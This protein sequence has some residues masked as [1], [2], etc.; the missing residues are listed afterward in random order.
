VNG[1]R[2]PPVPPKRERQRPL[3]WHQPKS[4]E[5]DAE[6]LARVQ[7][8]LAS[9]TYR[10]ADE[11][12]ALL[13]QPAMRGVRLHLDYAKAE[14]VLA[15]HSI[16]HAIIVFGGTRISEPA[17][18]ERRLAASRAALHA[19]PR[20][21]DAQRDVRIAERIVANSRYYDVARDLGRIA[22]ASR[23][24]A[25]GHRVVVMTGAGPG[26]MEAANR[27]A[28]D[29]GA[30]TAGLNVR[31]AN[32]QFPN[33]Y[34][35]PEL[36]FRF[37]YFAIRKLHFIQRAKAIVV[38]PG[39]YGTFDELFEALALVQT[40]TIAPIP[41]VLVGEDYWRRAIDFAF[42][43]DEGVVD[44]EDVELFWYAETAQEIWNGIEDWH[45]HPEKPARPA[46][47]ISAVMP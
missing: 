3:P 18:A 32:P 33:P 1:I 38:F 36:C 12:L 5:D 22:G 9:P 41:I 21:A 40:R 20:D 37:H 17:A 28:F 46:A 31:L 19:A 39:G 2:R 26:I 42:L 14:E 34:V 24:D 11:D 30:E 16:V 47:N 4:A 27:G 29:V 35:T 6:A 23:H 44:P 10:E 43:V 7:R 8:L 13:Q 25:T 15:A 45:A